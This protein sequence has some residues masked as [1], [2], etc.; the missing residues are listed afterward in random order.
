MAVPGW[1]GGHSRGSSWTLRGGVMKAGFG[2]I[3]DVLVPWWAERGEDF[4][5]DRT[6]AI[7]RGMLT[8]TVHTE[9]GG[10]IPTT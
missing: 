7:E 6:G 2:G 5:A 1:S 3:W 4:V 10:G 9:R 8:T